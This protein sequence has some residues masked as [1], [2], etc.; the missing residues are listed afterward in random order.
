MLPQLTERERDVS[1]LLAGGLSNAATDRRPNIAPK[2]VGQPHFSAI[3]L[4]LGVATFTDAIVMSGNAALGRHAPM[5]KPGPSAWHG[6]SS[7]MYTKWCLLYIGSM[8][9]TMSVAD[10]RK[11]FAEALER[12]GEGPVFIER[13]GRRAAVL[14]SPSEY[15][16]LLDAV[17]EQE[18]VTAFDEAMADEGPNIP[19]SQV[20]VDLGWA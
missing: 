4:T 8:A 10:A 17:E 5:K 6:R 13:R 16:R 7:V 15:E 20:K 3:L 1:N 11:S 18:D 19:W 9:S 14:I 12:S 2:S